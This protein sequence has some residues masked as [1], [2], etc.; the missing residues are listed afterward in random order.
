MFVPLILSRSKGG[1][2]RGVVL[3]AR[4]ERW[5]GIAQVVGL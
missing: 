4:H 5:K 2:N 1:R 3:P